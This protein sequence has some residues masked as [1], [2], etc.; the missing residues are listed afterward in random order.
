MIGLYGNELDLGERFK[1]TLENMMLLH[2]LKNNYEAFKVKYKE[3]VNE[4]VSDLNQIHS[5]SSFTPMRRNLY[6]KVMFLAR[7]DLVIKPKTFRAIHIENFYIVKEALWEQYMNLFIPRKKIMMLAKYFYE[8]NSF[9]NLAP[10]TF[11]ISD[12]KPNIELRLDTADTKE[13]KSSSQMSIKHLKHPFIVK[14]FTNNLLQEDWDIKLA[15]KIYNSETFEP[16]PKCE[17]NCTSIKFLTRCYNSYTQKELCFLLKQNF[18]Y[19]LLQIFHN[20]GYT[21]ELKNNLNLKT[22]LPE[23]SRLS[24]IN[25]NPLELKPDICLIYNKRLINEIAVALTMYVC[26]PSTLKKYIQDFHDDNGRNSSKTNNIRKIFTKQFCHSL[27]TFNSYGI[28]TDYNTFWIYTYD[29]NVAALE[30]Q[31]TNSENLIELSKSG[32]Q[33]EIIETRNGLCFAKI[34]SFILD[35]LSNVVEDSEELLVKCLNNTMLENLG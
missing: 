25:E 5:L 35:N 4:F 22:Q 20:L 34:A 27:S 26:E 12:K 13:T 10:L 23:D 6:R 32:I 30:K 29:G 2:R 11:P 14:D 18:L 9:F 7:F 17:F 8:I 28:I 16:I 19:P 24:G 3:L 1:L 33:S 31:K 15:F 21:F